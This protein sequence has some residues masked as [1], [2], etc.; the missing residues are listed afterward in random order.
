MCFSILL[1]ISCILSNKEYI[2]HIDLCDLLKCIRARLLS[3]SSIPLLKTLLKALY[4]NLNPI[5]FAYEMSES[6]ALAIQSQTLL[7]CIS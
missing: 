2:S 5:C 4:R 7:K 6:S 1:P 3:Q